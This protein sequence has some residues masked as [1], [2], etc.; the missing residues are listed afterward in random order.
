MSEFMHTF[1]GTAATPTNKIR[2]KP[3]FFWAVKQIVLVTDYKILH[4][5]SQKGS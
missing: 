2:T 5:R 1:E 4:G 3:S